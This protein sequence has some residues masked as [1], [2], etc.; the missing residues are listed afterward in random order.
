MNAVSLDIRSGVR[1]RP[2][3]VALALGAA[4]SLTIMAACGSADGPEPGATNVVKTG[5][6]PAY[7]PA[8]YADVIAAS[9]AEGGE[10]TIYSNTDQ[11]NWDPIF[12]D[13]KKKYPWVTKISANNLDSDEVFQKVLSEQATS[14]SPAD[15]LVSNAAQA[16]ADFAERPDTLLEYTS[17]EVQK[18]PKVATLMPNVYA[19]STDPMSIV[20]NASLMK[21]KPTGLKSLADIVSKDPNTYKG[22][23]TTR[24]VNG[25]FG[26]TVSHAF[27]EAR[28][29]SW[30]SLEKILPLGKAETSSGTQLE[31]ITAGEYLAGFFVSAAP[32]YPKVEQSGG[33]LGIT[34]LDDGTVVLPRGIGIAAK[35]PH[36]ATAKLFTDFVLSEEG[37]RA[38]A[39]G[40]LTSYREGIEATDG[41]H[42]YQ[43]LVKKV[44]EDNVIN[45]EYTKVPE[46]EVKAFTTRWDGLLGR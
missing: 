27:T 8:D 36:T 42:T 7:Y 24:D 44:G 19:M 35:A 28:P 15:V 29:D 23:I 13:F 46:D 45:V 21:D 43:E 5:E 22:K 16:W 10:L 14:G 37:Q 38:V 33:L 18:L 11:E 41:R 9:K 31:K 32:A 4:A 20:Y 3:R 34:F 40:G 30:T 17:P 26:F 6:A 2:A 25:A 12:R 39:E 1:R